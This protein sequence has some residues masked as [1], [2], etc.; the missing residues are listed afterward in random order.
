MVQRFSEERR[1][2][3]ALEGCG[4][5]PHRQFSLG[6]VTARLEAE[7]FQITAADTKTPDSEPLVLGFFDQRFER[8]R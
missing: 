6:S 2:G 8:L 3:S 4:F 7:P 5:E 1:L